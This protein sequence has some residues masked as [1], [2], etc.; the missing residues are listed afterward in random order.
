MEN[1]LDKKALVEE[2]KDTKEMMANSFDEQL[3]NIEVTKE[4]LKMLRDKLSQFPKYVI[5]R[6]VKQY[7]ILKKLGVVEKEADLVGR[8]DNA[9]SFLES[10]LNNQAS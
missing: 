10:Q 7:H 2:F 9:I 8:L 5:E 4:E 6:E 1:K 3:G